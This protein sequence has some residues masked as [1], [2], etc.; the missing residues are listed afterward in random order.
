MKLIFYESTVYFLQEP[1]AR[2]E[3]IYF[4]NLIDNHLVSFCL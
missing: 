2:S 3:L 1:E 4:E